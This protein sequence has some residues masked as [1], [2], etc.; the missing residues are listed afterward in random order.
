MY[1]HLLKRIM[2]R[3]LLF[4]S[5]LLSVMLS[6]T[7]QEEIKLYPKGPKENN[8]LKKAEAFADAEF[9]VDITDAR[10]Y[11]YPAPADKANGTAVVICPGGGYVGVSQIKEG[12]EIAA[13]FN[14]LGVSAFVLYYRM[15]NGHYNVPLT[16]AQTALSLIRKDAKKWKIDKN[17]I[18]IMGFSAGGHLAATAGTHFKN[19][20]QRPAFMILIYPVITMDGSYTHA[21]SRNSLL[22]AQPSAE[23]VRLFSN[24]LQVK[25]N[26]PPAFLVHAIDDGVVPVANS[27]NML[28]AL[29]QMNVPAEYQEYDLGG[30]G[31]G[32]RKKNLPVDNWPEMLKAWL[33]KQKLVK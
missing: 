7:A 11:A 13:W 22:G 20:Q 24:E 21:G 26:N 5:I 27:R 33:V 16:D 15:P 9:I 28:K 19:K 23:L 18:G 1:K 14:Q 30:H 8:E 17:K 4:L 31:F 2:M 32:M 12:S 25:K 29:Q 3:Q 10:M 6:A